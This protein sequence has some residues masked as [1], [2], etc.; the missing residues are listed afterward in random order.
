MWA[1]LF[2]VDRLLRERSRR[3]GTTS[4]LDVMRL[5]VNVF[6]YQLQGRL[7]SGT[8]RVWCLFPCT[9]WIDVWG[10]AMNRLHH[11]SDIVPSAMKAWPE[12]CPPLVFFFPSFFPLCLSLFHINVGYM[13]LTHKR[14]KSSSLNPMPQS[15][16]S[17]TSASFQL[18]SLALYHKCSPSPQ[19]SYN[20]TI[21]RQPWAK[22]QWMA[23]QGSGMGSLK[24]WKCLKQQQS[25]HC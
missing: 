12:E 21:I 15:I 19:L 16:N 6:Q 8:C 2:P 13:Q 1:D 11:F 18:L 7:T 10:A 3:V 14:Q 5:V 24:G 25:P 17:L 23:S 9:L 20:L 4:Q 22:P